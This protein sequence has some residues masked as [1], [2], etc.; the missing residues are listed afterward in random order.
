MSGICVKTAMIQLFSVATFL[1]GRA[2]LAKKVS[3]EIGPENS[4]RELEIVEQG[5]YFPCS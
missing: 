2:R 5:V 4:S 1:G 3:V